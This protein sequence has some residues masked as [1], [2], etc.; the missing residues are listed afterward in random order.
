MSKFFEKHE[1]LCLIILI[2]G[3]VII[4]SYCMNNFGYTSSKSPKL[5]KI[6]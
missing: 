2:A 1:T 5:V 4:N 3:Y 6:L